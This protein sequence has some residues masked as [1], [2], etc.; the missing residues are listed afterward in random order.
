M[1]FHFLI[2]IRLKCFWYNLEK[3]DL[4]CFQFSKKKKIPVISRQCYEMDCGNR[5]CLAKWFGY[6]WSLWWVKY[7]R[8]NNILNLCAQIF[9]T[10]SCGSQT[11]NYFT[12]LVEIWKWLS[13]HEQ[14]TYIWLH[15]P[16]ENSIKS[17]ILVIILFE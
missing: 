9:R 13:S 11:V 7:F 16:S 12:I 8:V 5:I 3:S 1:I 2:S 17:S 6:L 4:S 10:N 15:A 14:L